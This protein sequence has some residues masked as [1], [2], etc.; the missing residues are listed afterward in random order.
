MKH[1]LPSTVAKLTEQAFDGIT[2]VPVCSILVR[3]LPHSEVCVISSVKHNLKPIF[4]FF[5]QFSLLM[6]LM[7]FRL[8]SL[9]AGPLNNFVLNVIK[10]LFSLLSSCLFWNNHDG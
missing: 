8:P 4:Q 9:I 3:L 10:I 5:F 6:S 2:K 7:I 1:L